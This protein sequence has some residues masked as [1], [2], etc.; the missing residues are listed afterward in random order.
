MIIL[1]IKGALSGN[2]ALKET[3]RPCC[4]EGRVCGF[5]ERALERKKAFLLG[6]LE[7]NF[8]GDDF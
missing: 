3:H 7:E 1:S 8:G 6:F 4:K 2:K 5:D